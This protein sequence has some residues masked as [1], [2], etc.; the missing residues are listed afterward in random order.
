MFR[1]NQEDEYDF[2]VKVL[3]VSNKNENGFL[4]PMTTMLVTLRRSNVGQL[5]ILL[6]FH[7]PTGLFGAL[8]LISFFIPPEQVPGRIG[9][10]MTILLISITSY[11]SLNMPA[12]RGF[13]YMELWFVGTQVPILLA[14]FEYG[15]I[16]A[17]QKF[18][19]EFKNFTRFLD[20]VSFFICLI[21][22]VCFNGF[23]WTTVPVF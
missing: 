7:L 12:S 4:Y 3:P 19:Q 23:Y 8:S 15:A 17:L 10:L 13:S 9:M 21:L 6:E 5:K 22:F 2:W 16:L 11:S 14:I 20:L 1:G 18:Y